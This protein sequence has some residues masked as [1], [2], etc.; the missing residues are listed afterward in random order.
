MLNR[1]LFILKVLVEGL[2]VYLLYRVIEVVL[3]RANNLGVPF[4]LLIA[5]AIPAIAGL[6]V[7]KSFRITRG[8][9]P[10]QRWTN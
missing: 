9:G 5:A 1:Y 8:F 7:W 6:V 4:T 2:S 3:G 10:A